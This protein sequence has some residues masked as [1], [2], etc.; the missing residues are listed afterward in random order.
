MS[1]MSTI[2]VDFTD[3]SGIKKNSES[4]KKGGKG[5][6]VKFS[7]IKVL[8][9]LIITAV[10]GGVCYYFML[11]PL[12]IKSTET[13]V[14]LFLILGI[15]AVVSLVTSG[16]KLEETT[17]VIEG[18]EYNQ[19]R[20]PKQMKTMLIVPAA[21]AAVL[22]VVMAFGFIS[23]AE[24]FR[25][26]SYAS[27]LTVDETTT[28]ADD[29][30]EADFDTVPVL[31]TASTKVLATRTLGDLASI[32]AVSQFEVAGNYNQ[33]NYGGTPYSVVTLAYG[34][35]FKW[36]SNTE[37][38]LPG[39]ISVDMVTQKAELVL[40]DEGEYMQYSPDEYFQEDLMR[41]V[42]FEYPTYMFDTETFEVDDSGYP[43]WIVPVL[44]KTVGLFGGTD[45][46]GVVVVDAVTGEMQD[47]TLEEL[48]TNEELAWIDGVYSS[49][50]L[51]EQYDYYGLYSNGWLNSMFGQDGVKLTTEDSNYL[52]MG[53]DI[54]MYTGVT[55]SGSDQAI[56]GFVLINM[57][58]KDANFY[59]VS[60]AKETS[61]MSSAEGE[62]Q[63]YS[64]SATFPLLLNICDQ[65]TYF[66]S[67]KDDDNLIRQY[68]MVSVQYYQVAV[69]GT[70]IAE[71]MEA[72]IEALA[73]NNIDIDYDIGE[74]EDLEDAATD[75][76]TDDEETVYI[77]VDGVIYEIRTAVLGGESMFYL[78]LEDSDVF[79]SIQ[80]SSYPEVIILNVGDEVSVEFEETDEDEVI[81]E[82][83]LV[84]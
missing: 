22:A 66:M 27:I 78:Q 25:A 18:K 55:S 39:Y 24:I 43:Y 34:D 81:I 4:N 50:L 79:Y 70:T 61:A 69:T 7:P 54:Y 59:S 10:I 68:S 51:V 64:Y 76:D 30:E 6:K 12:N 31:D 8:L 75:E 35:I 73:K 62:V 74:L 29:I 58:T 52:T 80:A 32:D 37:E 67:L 77:Q 36:F 11:P 65:P 1:I 57:R 23:S 3:K 21:I 13:Y 82:A 38:G 42:R 33:I 46:T 5:D 44:D 14:F 40:F 48:S 16:I 71:C 26:K 56:I 41:I 19:P 9:N 53:D 49:D 72:Y 15:Y 47:Y 45:V 83:A 17:V 63:N 2:K 60:G 20:I 28:F 84:D